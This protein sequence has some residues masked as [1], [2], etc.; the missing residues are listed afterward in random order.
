MEYLAVFAFAIILTIPLILIFSVQTQN[1]QMDVSY[2]QTYRALSKIC[3]SAEEIYFQ[4]TPARKT[5]RITFPQGIQSITVNSTYI[6]ASFYDGKTNITITKDTS[7]V[8][9]GTLRSFSGEH[10]IVFTAESDG[11]LLEDK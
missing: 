5:I 8:L 3:D 7:A 9:K 4:G 11:V 2:A 1:M 6:E 10:R